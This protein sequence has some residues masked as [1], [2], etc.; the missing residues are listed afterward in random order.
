MKDIVSIRELGW[1]AS[2]SPLWKTSKRDRERERERERVTHVENER[3]RE[4]ERDFAITFFSPFRYNT[5]PIDIVHCIII[6]LY[7]QMKILIG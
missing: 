1:L 2:K 6:V 4:R 5:I 3:E 7:D